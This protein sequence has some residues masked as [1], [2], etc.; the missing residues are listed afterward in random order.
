MVGRPRSEASRRAILEAALRLCERDGY[1]NVT[2]KAVAAEAGTGRQTLYRWWNTKADVLLEAMTT[3]VAPRI[4]PS[5]PDLRSFLLDTFALT[6]GVAGR[7]VVGLMA[8]AQSDPDLAE[9]L[10]TLLIGPRRAALRK[11]LEGALSSH[12]D[13]DLTVDMIFGAMWYRLLNR[14]APVDAALAEEITDL[15][16]RIS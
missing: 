13:L 1:P 7:V 4:P 10:R 16:R 3:I 8:E 9:R 5:P 2:L 15:V 12:A 6:D 11:V 14:H